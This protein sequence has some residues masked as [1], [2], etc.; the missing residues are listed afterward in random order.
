VIVPGD[1]AELGRNA[2]GEVSRASAM[3][4][5]LMTLNKRV[6]T[7]TTIWLPTMTAIDTSPR[8]RVADLDVG[9]IPVAHAKGLEAVLTGIRKKSRGDDARLREALRVFDFVY[10]GYG[11]PKAP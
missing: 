10:A 11:D 2:F 5:T 3:S 4:P 9:G 1:Y 7:S 6:I 8:E